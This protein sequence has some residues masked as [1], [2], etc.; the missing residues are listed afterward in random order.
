MR[1]CISNLCMEV[2]SDVLPLLTPTGNNKARVEPS[3]HCY[4]LN[5]KSKQPFMLK[6]FMFLG[7]FLGWSLRNMG[8][9]AIDLPNAFWTRICKGSQ[10]YSYSLEDLREM[11]S[12]RAEFLSQIS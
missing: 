7:Y 3:M 10:N 2:M 4:Q 11:D 9:L 12:H 8:G 1:D 5:P 6:K